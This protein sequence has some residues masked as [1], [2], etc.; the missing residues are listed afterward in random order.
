MIRQVL[1]AAGFVRREHTDY[2]GHFTVVSGDYVQ[3]LHELC[4]VLG[5]ELELV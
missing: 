3:K 4:E 2:G 1:D 5:V